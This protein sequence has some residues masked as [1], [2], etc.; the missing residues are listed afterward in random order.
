MLLRRNADRILLREPAHP[1][2]KHIRLL[3]QEKSVPSAFIDMPYL[4]CRLI[5][6]RREAIMIFSTDLDHTLILPERHLRGSAPVTAVEQQLRPFSYMTPGALVG[7][8]QKT[9]SASS[10]RCAGM[11][12]HARLISSR[13]E[14]R[15]LALQMGCTLPGWGVDRLGT[16]SRGP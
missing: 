16:A 4:C 8:G 11:N 2:L 14:L 5:A 15:Y 9:R 3:A 10:I 12:G 13:R 1:T 7:G 6:D